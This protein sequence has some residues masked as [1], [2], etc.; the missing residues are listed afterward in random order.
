MKAKIKYAIYEYRTEQQKWVAYSDFYD[1]KKEAHRVIN[2]LG[3]DD[4][5]PDDEMRIFKLEK[6]Y[7]I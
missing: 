1:T 3:H 2:K 5:L 7:T 4:M 6:L